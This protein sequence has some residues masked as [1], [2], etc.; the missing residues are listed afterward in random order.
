MLI[1]FSPSQAFS[2]LWRLR[3]LRHLLV[4]GRVSDLALVQLSELTDLTSF[5]RLELGMDY[6]CECWDDSATDLALQHSQV[7]VGRGRGS[8]AVWAHAVKPALTMS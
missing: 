6:G 2:E 5:R 4:A 7:C 8:P 3:Q 1:P